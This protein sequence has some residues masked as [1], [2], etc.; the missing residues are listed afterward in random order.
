[1]RRWD[2]PAIAYDLFEARDVAVDSDERRACQKALARLV[3]EGLV[4]SRPFDSHAH[5]TGYFDP[6]ADGARFEYEAAP[7]RRPERGFFEAWRVYVETFDVGSRS[8]RRC[9]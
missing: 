2:G 9:A 1:M 8:L 5:R 3:E 6:H 4:V 7:W